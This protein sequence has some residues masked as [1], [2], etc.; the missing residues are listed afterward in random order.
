V[1]P[2]GRK[3]VTFLGRI[4]YQKGPEYFVEA[5]KRTLDVFPDSHF[6]MAGSGDALPRMIRKV[7]EKGMSS[8]FHF[9]GF[10]KKN[11]IDRLLACTRVYVMPSVSEPFGITPLEA[12]Q[13]GVP[14]II[15]RQSGVGEVLPD[16]LKVDFWDTDA[17]AQS[18]CSVLRYPSLSNTLKK[19]GAG[20]LG[21][22]SWEAAAKKV[23]RIYY[24]TIN[25][26]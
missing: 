26:N 22:I 17:L 21:A 13:A 6:V 16:A 8:N 10:L 12:V 1:H 19:N 3:L 25:G 15:S 24:E 14:V 7:A 4:T 20:R 18:I 5:A 2:V 11:D 23:K 9:T